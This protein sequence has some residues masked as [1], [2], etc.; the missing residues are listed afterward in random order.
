MSLPVSA[1]ECIAKPKRLTEPYQYRSAGKW[2]S[3]QMYVIGWP[4]GI[5]KVGSTGNGRERWGKFL[6][7]GGV[8][9]DLAYFKDCG[10]L[11]AE[12]WLQEQLDGLYPRAFNAKHESLPYLGDGCG[13]MEC[14]RI[15]RDEW[16]LV[17]EIAGEL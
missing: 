15:P 17:V 6:S 1:C 2:Y 12:T 5:V 3:S 10:D 8:M 7:R 16:E 9:L 11:H 13:Y 4:D 14:Y